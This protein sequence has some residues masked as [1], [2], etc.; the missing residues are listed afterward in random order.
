[1]N[2]PA[3][4]SYSLIKGISSHFSLL[5]IATHIT[6]SWTSWYADWQLNPAVGRLSIVT[7]SHQVLLLSGQFLVV[8]RP[9]LRVD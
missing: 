7:E 8:H 2:A 5:A 9:I 3:Q 6:T 1:M 4:F